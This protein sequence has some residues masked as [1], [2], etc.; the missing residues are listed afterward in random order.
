MRFDDEVR[1]FIEELVLPLR[2]TDLCKIVAALL[3]DLKRLN[4]FV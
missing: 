3:V 2:R 4:S 1:K